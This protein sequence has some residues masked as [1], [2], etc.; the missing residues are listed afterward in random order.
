MTALT[1]L[2]M[3]AGY[4]ILIYLRIQRPPNWIAESQL[5]I[6][7]L[8]LKTYF[9]LDGTFQILSFLCLFVYLA[10]LALLTERIWFGRQP[11]NDAAITVPPNVH[12]YPSHT[13]MGIKL[14]PQT[15]EAPSFP[16]EL[17]FLIYILFGLL[18]TITCIIL[19]A[20]S[21]NSSWFWLL[22]CYFISGLI[23]LVRA[24]TA[25]PN[26]SPKQRKNTEQ[27]DK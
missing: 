14:P 6:C 15:E 17:A 20:I 7:A 2:T 13:F 8:T 4:G 21:K 26:N 27:S 22:P 12:W 10:Y 19:A 24:N 3:L 1:T 25:Q 5:I 18:C 23:A 9:W 11:S 16:L